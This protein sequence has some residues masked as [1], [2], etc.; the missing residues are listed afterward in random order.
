MTATVRRLG[1]QVFAKNDFAAGQLHA[2]HG[3][4]PG[5]KIGEDRQAVEH[6]DL[7]VLGDHGIHRAVDQLAAG[8]RRQSVP[9]EDHRAFAP[10][11]L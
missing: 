3:I 1:W 7:R 10:R 2:M 11:L 9:D 5:P 8:V 4:A 6:G